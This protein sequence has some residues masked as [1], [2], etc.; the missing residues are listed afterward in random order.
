MNFNVDPV[1]ITLQSL[2]LRFS[3]DKEDDNAR[4]GLFW[5]RDGR[6]SCL[7]GWNMTTCDFHDLTGH[8]SPL[9][10]LMEHKIAAL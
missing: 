6:T 5:S 7:E 1:S 10:H 9:R 3:Y 2:E 4:G 8:G